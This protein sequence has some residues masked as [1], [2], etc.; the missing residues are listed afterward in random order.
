MNL[1]ILVENILVLKKQAKEMGLS[2]KKLGNLEIIQKSG[3]RATVSES[4]KLSICKDTTGKFYIL[5][6]SYNTKED[7]V[8]RVNQG[9][10]FL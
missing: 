5:K 2:M 6:D 10:K 3:N 9:T 4:I 1:G 8:A 7:A